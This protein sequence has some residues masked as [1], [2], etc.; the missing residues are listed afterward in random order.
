MR[1]RCLL[2]QFAFRQAH[3]SMRL[4]SSFP[5]TDL[6]T[7]Y[8]SDVYDPEATRAQNRSHIVVGR[9]QYA[10]W[11]DDG[12]RVSHWTS[13]TA[14]SLDEFIKRFHHSKI[15]GEHAL[16]PLII[17]QILNGPYVEFMIRG[18]ANVFEEKRRKVKDAIVQLLEH[19]L[20]SFTHRAITKMLAFT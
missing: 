7:C 20:S 18:E 14:T 1:L 9:G 17:T 4:G 2:F 19:Y 16:Y 11:F 3:E 15:Y 8:H 5:A 6:P 13:W 12:E 10:F